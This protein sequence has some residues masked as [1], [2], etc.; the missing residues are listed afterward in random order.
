MFFLSLTLYILMYSWPASKEPA[1]L[2]TLLVGLTFALVAGDLEGA[3]ESYLACLGASAASDT[4]PQSYPQLWAW[5]DLRQPTP[6]QSAS[7]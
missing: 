4:P 6:L 2:S 1:P 3:K 5:Q 7:Q